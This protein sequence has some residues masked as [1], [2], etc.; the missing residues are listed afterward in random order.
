MSKITINLDQLEDYLRYIKYLE[1]LLLALHD[2]N[3]QRC[4]DCDD[5][6]EVGDG[7]RCDGQLRLLCRGGSEYD[8]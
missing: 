1:G 3:F 6:Y 2:K 4:T 5:I 7:H 8:L